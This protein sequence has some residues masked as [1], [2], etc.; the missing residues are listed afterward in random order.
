MTCQTGS[1]GDGGCEETYD[2]SREE[3]SKIAT[4]RDGVGGDVGAKLSQNEAGGDEP[5][6]EAG[7]TA[8]S[9]PIRIIIKEPK[10]SRTFVNRCDTKRLERKKRIVLVLTFPEE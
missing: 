8:R 10:Q 1:Q 6:T 9:I 5:D 4:C 7:G 3:R 2:K